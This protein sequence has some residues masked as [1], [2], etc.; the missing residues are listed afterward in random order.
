MLFVKKLHADAKL[1]TCSHPGS[2]L[3]YDV[4]ALEDV[5][6]D[7]HKIYRVRTGIAAQFHTSWFGRGRYGLI[8]KDRS[9]VAESGLF[10]VG[11]VIDSS[12]TGELFVMFRNVSQVIV[13]IKAGQK[14]AQIIPIEVLTEAM[15]LETDVLPNTERGDRGF[16]S[17]GK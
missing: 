2:D 10:T 1:P 17:S 6:I 12:Y 8:V 14:I 5:E 4:Y 9:S 7:P 13:D 15:V 3:A 16:G 11:G